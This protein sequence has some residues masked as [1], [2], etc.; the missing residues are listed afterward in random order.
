MLRNVTLKTLRDL[1]AGFL[2][3]GLGLAGMVALMLSVYPTVRANPALNRLVQQYPDAL[4]AFIGF[5]GEVDYLSPAGYLG[6]EL[7]SFMV[8]LLLLVAAIGAGARAVAGEEEMGTLELLLSCPVSRR[9]MV[10]EKLA[11]LAI[12]VAGLGAVLL[13]S[14]WVGSRAVSM[15]VSFAHLAAATVAAVLL[16][17]AY[18]ALALLVGAAT[19]RRALTIGVVAAAAVAAYLVASLASLVDLLE[20]AKLAS[21]FYHYSAGDPLRH[22]LAAGHTLVLVAIAVVAGLLSPLALERRDVGVG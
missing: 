6:S 10:L 22:G 20:P 15:D 7:F 2:W 4:K 21:P 11:A 5:G 3:W 9:L 8:P 13:V 16:A 17:L 18:G 1:R 19:G 14:L 12:E